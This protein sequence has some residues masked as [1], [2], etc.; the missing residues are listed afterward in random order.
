MYN[1][2][3]IVAIGT[4]DLTTIITLPLRFELIQRIL[5]MAAKKKS[6]IFFGAHWINVKFVIFILY[7]QIRHNAY[8]GSKKQKCEKSEQSITWAYIG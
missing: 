4:H 6:I 8:P 3:F 1:G 2:H 7:N 5:N